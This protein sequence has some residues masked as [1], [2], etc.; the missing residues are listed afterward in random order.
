[1]AK[2]YTDNFTDQQF[3]KKL[4]SLP[5]GYRELRYRAKL[6]WYVLQDPLVPIALKASVVAALGY[7]ICPIDAVPDFIPGGFLDDLAV[8][9]GLLKA[10]DAYV[11]PEMRETARG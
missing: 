6:L 7:L 8:I 11:T 2:S 1:M 10:V 3:W 5:S 9:T 4:Y